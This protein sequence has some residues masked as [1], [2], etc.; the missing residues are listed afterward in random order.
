MYSRPT[1][2]LIRKPIIPL[3]LYSILNET[4]H[5]KL[6]TTLKTAVENGEGI[7]DKDATSQDD[8]FYAFRMSAVLTLISTFSRPTEIATQVV[9]MDMQN[10]VFHVRLYHSETP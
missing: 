1:P 2:L 6:I 10:R 9:Q 8:L 3:F 5:Y 7:L 4:K